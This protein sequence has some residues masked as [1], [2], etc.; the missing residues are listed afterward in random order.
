AAVAVAVERAVN[1]AAVTQQRTALIARESRVELLTGSG[2]TATSLSIL[3]GVSCTDAQ[4]RLDHAD[5]LLGQRNAV[6]QRVPARY[7]AL[8]AAQDAGLLGPAQ[9]KLTL[10][11]LRRLR[12]A[13]VAPERIAQAEAYLAEHAGMFTPTDLV[14]VC[15]RL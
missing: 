9:A 14:R 15:A 4:R 5:A 8:A 10:G 3:L 1:R 6:G 11:T 12:M 7:E 13:E 2:G